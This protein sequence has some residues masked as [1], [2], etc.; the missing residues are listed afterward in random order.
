VSRAKPPCELKVMRVRECPM[1]VA[2]VDTPETVADYWR[3]NIP[4][5][6]WYDP[7]KEAFIVLLLNT[8]RRVL[9]HNLVSQGTLDSS[10]VMPREVFRPAIASAASALILMHNHP[11]GE[12]MPSE[13]DIRITRELVR[14]GK[15]LRIDILDHVIIG[16]R[17][18]PPGFQSLRETG[19]L[20]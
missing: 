8:R 17:S 19:Y 6:D 12:P 13:A 11:S 20:G 16:D 5:A 9:G 3:T 4:A 7:D 14:A 2:K 10:L 15:L 1:E 18:H